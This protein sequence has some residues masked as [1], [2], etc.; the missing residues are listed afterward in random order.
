MGI[1]Y[2]EKDRILGMYLGKAIGGTL[3]QP[4]EGSTGPLKL[5]FYDPVPQEMIP[6]D[7]LD[8]QVIRACL[9]AEKWNAVL[10][11][12]NMKD[13]WIDCID[14]P[15]DE[16][17]VA[18]RNL[19]LGI[20]APW[21]GRY[22]NAFTDGL[23][24]AIRSEL[25]AAL[26]PGDPQLAARM[27]RLDARVDH[28]GEGV[29]AEMFLAAMEAALFNGGDL[30][31][32]I[33]IGLEVI[34]PSS[35][36]AQ[37]VRRTV[38]W[39]EHGSFETVR[40][41]I[42]AEFGS[43]NFTDVVMNL[44]FVVAALLLGEG[45]FG[46]TICLAVNFGQDADCTGASA[47]AIIGGL[48]PEAIPA[49][50]LAPIGR[51]L[52]ISPGYHAQN[53]PSTIDAFV[54]LLVGLR[55]R[56]RLDESEPT[57][58]DWN[59]FAFTMKEGCAAPFFSL[60]SAKFHPESVE[61]SRLVTVPG[62]YFEVDFSGME[63]D[64]LLLRELDFD[65]PQIQTVRLLVNTP[66]YVRVWLDGTECFGREGGRWVPAFHRAP[67]NQSRKIE[68]PAG[69][70]TLRMGFAPATPAMRRAA[71]LMGISTPNCQWLPLFR[72]A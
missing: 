9:L 43:D 26:A 31:T 28:D 40:A 51:D 48:Y 58:P 56:V 41:Q 37:A 2:S 44:P 29:W 38:A 16:Y 65:L 46:R 59:R 25:W 67:L 24:G 6:N 22:D 36:L 11:Y 57:E 55:H 1:N 32:L 68:L 23:G 7:D 15:C 62:N 54:D 60:D 12:A 33:E 30:R 10:S 13:A 52:V 4:W 18:I 49:R 42:M 39:C 69:R 61:L 53:P 71:V 3:G 63:P 72:L 47:G 34:P 64:A 45:D 17:G 20:P 70:H 14:F 21:S 8:L 66:A 35:R 27:A 50:W 5:D 19:Q